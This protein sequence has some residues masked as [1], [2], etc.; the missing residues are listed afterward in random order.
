MSL[1]HHTFLHK[2]KA[3]QQTEHDLEL[4]NPIIVG[5]DVSSVLHHCNHLEGPGGHSKYTILD[6]SLQSCRIKLTCHL[7]ND[8][9]GTPPPFFNSNSKLT[10]T[11]TQKILESLT[12]TTKTKGGEARKGSSKPK[13]GIL[14]QTF[15][16]VE[17]QN[18]TKNK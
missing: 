13:S 2:P 16:S 6:W 5:H 10:T 7:R 8:R 18:T 4:S 12:L 3:T 17:K 11:V 9:Q 15:S 1:L 14:P